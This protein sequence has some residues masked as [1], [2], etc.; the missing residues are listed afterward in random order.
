MHKLVSLG[1]IDGIIFSCHSSNE[2]VLSAAMQALNL[3]AQNEEVQHTLVVKGALVALFRVCTSKQV[4]NLN[5]LYAV[6]KQ[7]SVPRDGGRQ[8]PSRAH[9]AVLAH[10]AVG[11]V[12]PERRDRAR[13]GAGTG[14]TRNLLPRHDMCAPFAVFS[15]A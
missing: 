13:R 14:C 12:F 3:I 9:V 7:R 5:P 6:A 2:E 10:A 11:P 8:R 15:A 1:G 4:Q